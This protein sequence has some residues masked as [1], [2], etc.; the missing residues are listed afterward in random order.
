M[1]PFIDQVAQAIFDKQ[2]PLNKLT[3]VLPSQRAKKYFQRA[4]YRTYKKPVFS[5]EIVTMDRW[6]KES[7]GLSILDSTRGL[8]KLYSIHQQ[9]HPSE[10]KGLDEFI[11]WGRT[12]LSDFDEIDRYLIQSKDLFKNL[13]DIKEIENW[14]FNAEELSPAQKRFMAFWDLLPEYYEVFNAQ[15]HKEKIIYM[16]GAYKILAE[17]IDLVFKKDRDC[18]FVFAGFNALS[19]AEIS[20]IKQIEK[21]GRASIF[22]DTDSFYLRNSSHEA[23]TFIRHFMEELGI[24]K[25]SFER[26]V[27]LTEKKEIE[28]I[29]CAQSTGQAKVSATILRKEIPANERSETVVLLADERLAVPV[30]K[31]IPKTIEQTNITLGLPLKNTAIR[32]W[33]DLLFRVQENMQQFNTK[34]IYHKDLIRFIKHPLIIA[35]TNEEERKSLQQ[36]EQNILSKNWLFIGLKS[37]SCS[38]RLQEVFTRFFTPWNND[39]TNA[40]KRIRQM[41]VHLFEAIQHEKNAIE[42]SIVFHFDQSIVKLQNVLEEFHPKIHLKTFKTLFNQHWINES[43]AYYGNP[44]EG[45][46]VMGLLETRLLDFKNLIVVGLNDGKMPPNNPIQTL[47]PMDL[48]KF[49]GLPTPREKQGLFAHHFYRLLHTAQRIWITHSSADGSMGMDEPSRYIMQLELEL[50]RQN[51]NIAF[52]QSYYTI[53]DEQQDSTSIRV[54]KSRSVQVRLQEYFEQGTSA[55]ALRTFLNCPLDFYYRYVLGFGE[56]ETVEEDIEASSFGSFIHETLEKLYQPFAKYDQQESVLNDPPKAITVQNIEQMITQSSALLKSAF[57]S[58]YQYNKEV[59]LGGKNYLSF[60]IA[61]HL[62]KRFLLQEKKTLK[63][64]SG[65]FFLASVE[66]KFERILTVNLPNGK[67][68]HVKFKGFIDRIDQVNG[69]TR[70]L[71][72]K[73]GKCTEE[74]VLIKKPY[75]DTSESQQLMKVIQ[76]EPYIFQLLIYNYL[77]FGKYKK[78]PQKT[79]IISL[80]NVQQ[81]PFFLKNELTDDMYSLME[82]FESALKEIVLTVFDEDKP[83][84]HELN[85]IYCQYC[86]G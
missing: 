74:N 39:L 67:E 49:H 20:I 12:L 16:G 33:V 52:K 66:S 23:G 10:D 15:L 44:L 77:Y 31:N 6:V 4:L 58:H 78:Y 5:P 13:A 84:E 65:H 29:N 64:T 54:P 34:S 18:H 76:K 55:S 32:S 70:I 86:E 19:P 68:I 8:F 83:F 60:E 75:R 7:C 72:Y 26:N 80:I 42:R 46:Q 48:R 21:M 53:S 30:I 28:V 11:K 40:I 24:P 57:E 50:T 2:I 36:I 9:L 41:N 69:E 47:I 3:I 38:P 59:L 71:D 61:D 17:N 37:I 22:M 79:G 81:S 63:E 27:L 25:P 35:F 43:I 14:S 45:L 73:S 82:L 1:N 51:P 85:S 62:T 56:E